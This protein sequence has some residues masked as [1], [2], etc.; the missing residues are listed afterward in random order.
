MKK[1]KNTTKEKKKMSIKQDRSYGV[2]YLDFFQNFKAPA[3]LGF[4]FDNVM[5]SHQKIWKR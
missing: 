1:V 4:N 3:G 2:N 5:A